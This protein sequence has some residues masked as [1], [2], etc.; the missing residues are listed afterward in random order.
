MPTL[1]KKTY[2]RILQRSRYCGIKMKKI[3]I[4]RDFFEH[5]LACLA[6]QKFINSVN[7]DGLMDGNYKKV[8]KRN[9]EVIDKAW[10]KGMDMLVD[11]DRQMEYKK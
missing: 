2:W 7:A 9:Q 8:Q 6:N 3:Q 5:L 1:F 11:F 4:D 10:K